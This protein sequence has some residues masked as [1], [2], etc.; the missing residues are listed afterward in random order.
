MTTPE[1]LR[2]ALWLFV[3][4]VFLYLSTSTGVLDFGD[5]WSM[6]QVTSSIVDRSQIDV[7]QTTPGSVP[8]AD[9]R[10]YSKYGLGQS[11]LAV[12]FYVAGMRL[13]TLAGIPSF[14]GKHFGQA[15][16]L[17]YVLTMLGV[18]ATAASVALLFLCCLTLG[19]DRRA[20]ALAALAL[21]L[22][23]FAWYWSRTFMTEPPSML[24]LLLAFYAQLRDARRPSPAWLA[25]AG[26]A[27]GYAL[28]LRMGNL[29]VLPGFG[30]WLA[31]ELWPPARGI[32][33]S[34]ARLA[35]WLVPVAAGIAGV[36]AYNVARF[37]SISDTGYGSASAHLGGAMWVGVY[38]FLFSPGRSMF[39][40][41]PIL[42]VAVAGW[43][44]LWRTR[45]RIAIVMVGIVV[46]YVL[47]HSRLPYWEGGGCWS[48]RYIATILPFFLLGLAALVDGSVR[49]G[50]WVTT[51]AL[52][53]ASVCVQMLGVLVPCIPYAMEM[54]ASGSLEKVMWHPAYAPL[55]E[56][57]RR[58]V[59]LQDP[60]SLAP[61]Y[62]NSSRLGW[63]QGLEFAAAAVLLALCVRSML[64]T[65]RGAQPGAAA[66]RAARG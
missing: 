59:Q 55:V 63:L 62:F 39:V 22:G 16:P 30:L 28:L 29:I 5:D 66:L 48:P 25:V 64:H 11:L 4:F 31:F 34:A 7:P 45:R 53:V 49:R 33:Q 42:L 57:A 51:A 41:A 61:W 18:V 37:G 65:S 23:T 10:Y 8:G 38:G 12:P 27:L 19:F 20:S 54:S 47:F 17:T 35:A 32:R 14:D 40:Y 60:I 21:G 9:G 58:L 52:A 15:T 2:H 1:D 46:P 26:T 44:H 43:F 13:S 3:S 36:A 56:H 24:L 6:L 50:T